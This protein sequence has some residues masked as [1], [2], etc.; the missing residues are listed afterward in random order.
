VLLG[1][2]PLDVAVG[3]SLL[4]IAMKSFAGFAGYAGHTPIDVSLAL[5]VTAAAVVGSV[6]GGALASRISP[7]HLRK[8][9]AWFVV[10][11]AIFILGQELPQVFGWGASSEPAVGPA[12]G[13]AVGVVL[14]TAPS[15]VA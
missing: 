4:V 8:A 13:P 15:V 12:G 2:L 5:F 1:G 10:V 3:T 6:G 9:F 7:D 14:P 11:M